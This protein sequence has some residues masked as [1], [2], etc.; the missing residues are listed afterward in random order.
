MAARNRSRAGGQGQTGS[1]IRRTLAALTGACPGMAATPE[2]TSG[3][4]DASGVTTLRC[5]PLWRIAPCPPSWQGLQPNRIQ[6][7]LPYNGQVGPTSACGFNR[8]QDWLA[9][10]R[11][12]TVSALSGGNCEL[13]DTSGGLTRAYSSGRDSTKTPEP[14]IVNSRIKAVAHSQIS[15]SSLTPHPY[16]DELRLNR[17]A[18]ALSQPLA[19]AASTAWTPPGPPCLMPAACSLRRFWSNRLDSP[20]SAEDSNCY[21]LHHKV[22]L[23]RGSLRGNR[24]PLPL[25]SSHWEVADGGG[26]GHLTATAL[27]PICTATSVHSSSQARDEEERKEPAREPDHQNQRTNTTM[28]ALAAAAA[29]H[30]KPYGPSSATSTSTGASFQP[31]QSTSSSKP[32][33]PSRLVQPFG[34]TSLPAYPLLHSVQQLQPSYSSIATTTTA[35]HPPTHRARHLSHN[36][37]LAHQSGR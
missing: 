2:R 34:A 10:F 37:S 30:R 12:E 21:R 27:S 14:T 7:F 18:T 17:L 5:W 6:L 8:G 19:M 31:C 4:P 20:Y 9:L 3:V 26:G 36:S 32:R 25:A 35:T 13:A 16:I 11:L 29:P 24:G 28:D 22:V 33:R 15:K 23:P 1:R